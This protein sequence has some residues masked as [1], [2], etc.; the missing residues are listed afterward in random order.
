M[1]HNWHFGLPLGV[2]F[3]TH[4]K[5]HHSASKDSLARWVKEAMKNSGIDISIY[6]PHSTRVASN[7]KMY[8]L[9]MPLK[10]V[11]KWGQWS[12]SSTFFTYY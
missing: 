7:T 10:D 6:K 2:F 9:G 11:L 5:P 12:N 1:S 4:G 3:F 8:N